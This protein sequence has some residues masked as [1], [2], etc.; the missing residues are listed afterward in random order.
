MPPQGPWSHLR[1]YRARVTVGIGALL[2]TNIAALTV[3]WLLGRTIEALQGSDP[4][5]DVPPLAAAMVGF[6]LLQAIVRIVS[7]VTLFN[8]ARMGEHDLRADLFEHLMHMDAAWFRKNPTGDVMSRLTN[9]VQTVRAL[10]GPGLLNL[11]NTTFVFATGLVLM[12]RI[13]PVLTLWALVPYPAVFFL[14]QAFGRRIYKASRAVQ[15]KLGALSSSVQEDL[16]GV[17]VIKNYTLERQRERRFVRMSKELLDENMVVTRIRGTMMPIL[18]AM[19][20]I[21]TVMVIYV[22]GH[23]VASGRISLGELVQF[24]AYLALLV[25]PTLALGWMISL[26]Q[27][28]FASWS[29]LA[30]ILDAQPGI[31]GGPR[32]LP[33]NSRGALSVSDLTVDV[34]GRRLLDRVSLDIP[35]GQTTAVVGR[36]GCGKSTLIEA[37]ARLIEVPAG[38]VRIDGIDIRELTLPALRGAIGY[39]PQEAFLFS[40]TIADNIAM[41]LDHRPGGP[42]A[43]A[44]ERRRL[45]EQ[46]AQAAGLDRDLR[47]LP[48][49]LDTLVGE[50]G[51]TLSGGQRQRVALARALASEPTVLLLD[52]SLSSVDAET[53]RQIL[54]HLDRVLAGRTAVLVSHRV[55]AVRRAQ[56][57]AVIDGGR[58]VEQGSHAELLAADGLYAELYRDQMAEELADI[59]EA[60]S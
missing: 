33:A 31:V 49:G 39:A 48:H 11:I 13:D 14:G 38:A 12:L 54:G 24:N 58:V 53:E 56:R 4:G 29:R 18:G 44:G 60:A 42:P 37:L 22:G 9:D 34:G 36:T 57:I 21:G 27:R 15:D 20:S 7:R 59:K 19:A 10:W 3:P 45:V 40:T 30:Y 43:D 1:R 23:A 17:A 6:A 35:A 46:A 50:R 2:I 32:T 26:V 51:I 5:G 47:A 28:G 55:A 25:W 52:D 41:G 8:A 16:T